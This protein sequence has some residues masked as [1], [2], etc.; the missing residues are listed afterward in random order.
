MRNTC[1]HDGM[2]PAF[3]GG[4]SPAGGMPQQPQAQQLPGP[5]PMGGQPRLQYPGPPQ[6]RLSPLHNLQSAP[7]RRP[8][9]LDAGRYAH[10]RMEAN[11]ESFL[12]VARLMVP[13]DSRRRSS[14]RCRRP[15]LRTACRSRPTA[16]RCSRSRMAGPPGSS[17]RRCAPQCA[18]ASVDMQQQ[19]AGSMASGCLVAQIPYRWL[20]QGFQQQAQPGGYPG[21]PPTGAANGLALPQQQPALQQAPAQPKPDWTEHKAPDGRPYWYNARTKQS[22]WNK[23]AELM[24]PE[25]SLAAAHATQRCRDAAAPHGVEA[26]WRLNKPRLRIS[27]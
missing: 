13:M 25:V 26:E 20:V 12:V 4:P 3:G 7:Q 2:Q 14:S 9:R 17:L 11:S 1:V 18:A 15:P 23:P 5:P 6:V 21:P 22:V 10:G 24:S 16:A 27:Q 8:L 19:S